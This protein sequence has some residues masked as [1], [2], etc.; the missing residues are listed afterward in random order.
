MLLTVLINI[1]K[2]SHF[3]CSLEF[4]LRT[5]K[6]IISQIVYPPLDELDEKLLTD[7]ANQMIQENK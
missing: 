3:C 6:T 1:V 2:A 5:K 7:I 4:E